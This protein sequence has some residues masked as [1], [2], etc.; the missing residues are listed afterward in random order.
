MNTENTPPTILTG[1]NINGQSV[2]LSEAQT[3][4]E[5]PMSR[6]IDKIKPCCYSEEHFIIICEAALQLVKESF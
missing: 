3:E 5:T 6:F 2:I 4:E 1:D